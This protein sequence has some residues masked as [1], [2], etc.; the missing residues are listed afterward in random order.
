MRIAGGSFT[1][2]RRAILGCY[3][4]KPLKTSENS[5]TEASSE[6]IQ[7]AA[8]SDSLLEGGKPQDNPA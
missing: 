6:A 4:S 1:C 3:S 8:Q 5:D 2:G 7:M